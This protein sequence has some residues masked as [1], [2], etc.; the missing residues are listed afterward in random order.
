M[1]LQLPHFKEIIIPVCVSLD[2]ALC[3]I[4]RLMEVANW[5]V[6]KNRHSAVLGGSATCTTI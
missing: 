2:I 1:A 5:A 4:L 6:P 3:T